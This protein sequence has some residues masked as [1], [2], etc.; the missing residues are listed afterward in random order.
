MS[1]PYQTQPYYDQLQAQRHNQTL[2][3]HLKPD[4]Q[5][6]SSSD[7]PEPLALPLSSYGHYMPPYHQAT[8]PYGNSQPFSA[9]I[10][11]H[12]PPNHPPVDV[13]SDFAK[14][15]A[16]CVESYASAQSR[17]MQQPINQH[18]LQ[19]PTQQDVIPQ[20]SAEFHAKVSRWSQA[21]PHPPLPIPHQCLR[22]YD[23]P[24][25]PVLPRSHAVQKPPGSPRTSDPRLAQR[26][27]PEA[28]PLHRTE[29]LESPVALLQAPPK[30]GR[31]WPMP[32]T[33]VQMPTRSA[34]LLS[35]VT[36]P[37][38]PTLGAGPVVNTMKRGHDDSPVVHTSPEDELD[39]PPDDPMSFL[40]KQQVKRLPGST[41]W[42][43][44]SQPHMYGNNQSK[45]C[46]T[47]THDPTYD[48]GAKTPLNDAHMMTAAN[49]L[50]KMYQGSKTDYSQPSQVS[51]PFRSMIRC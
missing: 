18:P 42:I 39:T 7:Q 34:Q 31:N 11:P 50:V 20:P 9:M 8:A 48:R 36:S 35:Q 26:P 21:I 19:R 29:V 40:L 46:Q 4:I 43:D 49:A 41:D 47:P 28:N 2:P 22:A 17:R 45:P 16:A 30:R 24:P 51:P 13:N 27:V 23:H 14:V 12:N 15:W 38:N 6:L 5:P 25:R 44:D 3:G 33:R 37:P 1:Y 32:S 10:Q